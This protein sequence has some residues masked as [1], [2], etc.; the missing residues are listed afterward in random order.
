MPIKHCPDLPL[1][2][3]G[4]LLELS[5]NLL[6]YSVLKVLLLVYWSENYCFNNTQLLFNLTIS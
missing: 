2:G 6:H 4:S 3:Q 5:I 1:I